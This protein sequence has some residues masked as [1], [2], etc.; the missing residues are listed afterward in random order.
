MY[1]IYESDHQ[2]R[3]DTYVLVTLNKPPGMAI[4]LENKTAWSKENNIGQ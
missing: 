4:I 1:I 3:F 2:I